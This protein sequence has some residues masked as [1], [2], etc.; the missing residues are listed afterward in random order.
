MERGGRRALTAL[1]ASVIMVLATACA[2]STEDVVAAQDDDSG[3]TT[4]TAARTASSDEEFV[5]EL[6][7]SLDSMHSCFAELSDEYFANFVDDEGQIDLEA[8]WFRASADQLDQTTTALPDAPTDPELATKYER[9]RVALAGWRS[10]AQQAADRLE[11][12]REELVA[13][14]GSGD[15]AAAFTAVIETVFAA[16]SEFESACLDLADLTAAETGIAL[17]CL[18]FREDEPPVDG[19]SAGQIGPMD[20]V[21]GDE[22]PILDQLSPNHVGIRSAENEELSFVLTSN[23]SFADPTGPLAGR[24]VEDGTDW[25]DDVPAW[26]ESLG[27]SVTNSGTTRIGDFDAEHWDFSGDEQRAVELTGTEPIVAIVGLDGNGSEPD[28]I[29][30]REF[31]V[32]RIY[33]IVIGPGGEGGVILGTGSGINPESADAEDFPSSVPSA[34]EAFDWIENDLLPNI[35]IL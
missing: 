35:S 11:A 27:G 3:Y 12:E 14:W 8:E 22:Q 13:G 20:V 24:Q 21:L 1:A 16:R 10:D 25:P 7:S 4:S 30:L 29:Q 26:L 5:Q 18:G 34:P 15:S 19:G 28:V 6:V 23:P 31:A 32:T 2:S 17:N 33:R 9:T